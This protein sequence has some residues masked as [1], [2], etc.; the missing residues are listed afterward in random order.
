MFTI[1]SVKNESAVHNYRYLEHTYLWF[2]LIF[3]SYTRSGRKAVLTQ[4]NIEA[5]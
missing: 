3:V 4:L 5:F 2:N 1:V